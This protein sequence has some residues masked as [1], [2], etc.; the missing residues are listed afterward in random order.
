V[1]AQIVTVPVE[2]LSLSRA[3]KL[4]FEEGETH[5]K[6]AKPAARGSNPENA[7]GY[8]K[9]YSRSHDAVIRVHDSG[10]T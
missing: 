3:V 6:G 9:F 7:I 10:A 2:S 1:P 8:A 4:G 5:Q